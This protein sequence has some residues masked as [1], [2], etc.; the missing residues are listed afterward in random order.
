M[1]SFMH[2]YLVMSEYSE[3]EDEAFEVPLDDGTALT[4]PGLSDDAETQARRQAR[5]SHLERQRSRE[6]SFSDKP[7]F[8][9][10]SSRTDLRRQLSKQVG[11]LLV[12]FL[13]HQS[14][15]QITSLISRSLV[16]FPDHQSRSQTTCLISRSLVLFP[17][18]G[19]VLF[20]SGILLRRIQFFRVFGW[21]DCNGKFLYTRNGMIVASNFGQLGRMLN[22][23]ND[24]EVHSCQLSFRFGQREE[25]FVCQN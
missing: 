3:Y 2:T 24:C 18:E 7:E 10:Y 22:C 23:Q 12:S 25:F 14:H 9:W 16:S 17:K 19:R 8:K 13:D 5:R 20:Q 4:T 1:T 6:A 11:M 15:S 21:Q